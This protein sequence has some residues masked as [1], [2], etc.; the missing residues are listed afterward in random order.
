MSSYYDIFKDVVNS[1]GCKIL[2]NEPMKNHTSFKIGGTAD[3]MMLPESEKVLS[4]ILKLCAQ[5]NIP[6]TFM[7][8]GSNML[9]SDSGIR[10]TV[11]KL[12]KAFSEISLLD[13]G[14]TVLCKSGASLSKLCSFAL[15]NGLSGLEFAWGIPGSVGGAA[16]MN[17]GA[18]GGEMKDVLIE[19]SHMDESGKSGAFLKESLDLSYRRSVYS[20]LKLII[21]SVKVKLNKCNPDRIKEKMTELMQR[22]LDKQPL[23]FPS[24]GSVFKRPEGHY[25]GAL[26]ESCGLKGFTI[27][28]AQISEKH[29]GFIIN[30]GNATCNDVIELI[31]HIQNKV[32]S[33]HSLLLECEIKVI[34]G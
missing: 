29:C 1:T 11:I 19:C 13:D 26:I 7:G 3:C 21:T 9:V 12:D 31:R 23:E 28:G 32:E 22:R 18:Y 25:A 14:V 27:G 10:G 2:I 4:D 20:D 34:G 5:N 17:A 30:K 15:S 8:N 16:F 24:A 33:V 6:V